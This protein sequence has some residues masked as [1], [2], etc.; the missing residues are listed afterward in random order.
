MRTISTLGLSNH[1]LSL[2]DGR[3]GHQELLM[4][5][6]ARQGVRNRA[7]LLGQVA[8]A[9]LE[10]RRAVLRGDLIRMGARF[11]EGYSYDALYATM[12]V[13]FQDDFATHNEIVIAWLLPILSSEREFIENHGWRE[14][15][16]LME[17]QDPDLT[18]LER[19]AI[20]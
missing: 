10:Q 7:G 20:V 12:P 1:G 17:S 4:L 18:D 9:C 16:D 2:G 5:F 6:L 14:F 15:E 11:F 8:T 3:I 13:Y 19:A